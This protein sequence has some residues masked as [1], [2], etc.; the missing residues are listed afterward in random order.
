MSVGTWPVWE[1]SEG[2]AAGQPKCEPAMLANRAGTLL[3]TSLW[4]MGIL[5]ATTSY[6]SPSSSSLFTGSTIS[7][8]ISSSSSFP[9]T[10]QSAVHQ[11]SWCPSTF[12]SC[13]WLGGL[14][15]GQLL[16]LLLKP[17]ACAP[18]PARASGSQACVPSHLG[19]VWLFATPGSV[20]NQAPLSKQKY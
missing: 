2:V 4:S 20:A 15:C 16:L 5:S 18:F 9:H 3:E 1:A 11:A 8:C 12:L 7:S 14:Y 13:D 19:C 10:P 6:F 17:A